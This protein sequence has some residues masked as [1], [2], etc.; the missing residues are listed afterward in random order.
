MTD[1]TFSGKSFLFS[2]VK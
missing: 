2:V 1:I